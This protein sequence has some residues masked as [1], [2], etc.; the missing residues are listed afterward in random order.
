MSEM[1]IS[2]LTRS[3]LSRLSETLANFGVVV[4]GGLVF[5]AFAGQNLS[6]GIVLSA[7]CASIF[8]IIMS[9]FLER[10]VRV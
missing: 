3:Q 8:L 1:K 10:G 5:P 6:A 9:L 2:P 4:A 7:S